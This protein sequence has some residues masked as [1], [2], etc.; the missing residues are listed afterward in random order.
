MNR[1]IHFYLFCFYFFE[2]ILCA[3]TIFFNHVRL[4]YIIFMEESYKDPHKLGIVELSKLQLLTMA[5]IFTTLKT[6]S[7]F[8]IIDPVYEIACELIEDEGP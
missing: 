2:I 8:W 3:Y 4:H 7:P 1:L 5:A 6:F